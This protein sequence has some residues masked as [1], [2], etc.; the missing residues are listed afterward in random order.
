LIDSPSL[1]LIDSSWKATSGGEDFDK[2]EQD[3]MTI[4]GVDEEVGVQDHTSCVGGKYPYSIGASLL[5]GYL[6]SA[7]VLRLT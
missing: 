1:S 4:T 7:V 6:P 2:K 5:Y 3:V